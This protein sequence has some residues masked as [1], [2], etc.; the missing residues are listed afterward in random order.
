MGEL[1]FGA[2]LL[3]VQSFVSWI[4]KKVLLVALVVVAISAVFPILPDDPLRSD[5]LTISA[6]FQQYADL[7]NWLIPVDFIVTSVLFAV[8]WKMTVYVFK[9]V[10]SL[11]GVNFMSMFTSYDSF[12]SSVVDDDRNWD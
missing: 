6:T 4:A 10:M 11:M 3:A 9:I 5:I 8:T 12:G 1:T 7:I 2:F